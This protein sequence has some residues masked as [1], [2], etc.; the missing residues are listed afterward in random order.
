MPGAMTWMALVKKTYAE[1]K[2]KNPKASYSDAM[3]AAK[4]KY[5]K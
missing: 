1:M 3:K 5:K 4:A 2:K